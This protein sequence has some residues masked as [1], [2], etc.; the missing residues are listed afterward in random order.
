VL[1]I[2]TGL[3]ILQHGTGE[4]LNFPVGPMNNASPLTPGRPA[5]LLELTGGILITLGLFTRT[6]RAAFTRSSIKG[7]WRCFTALSFSIWRPLALG[8]GASTG[9]C[10]AGR[11]NLK[12]KQ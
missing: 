11:R 8:L 7:S 9:R 5:G 12:R 6:H 10:G 3:L 1:R 4:Y 2:I